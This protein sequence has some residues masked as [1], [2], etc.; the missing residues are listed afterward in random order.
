MQYKH[1]EKQQSTKQLEPLKLSHS[2][3]MVLAFSPFLYQE[4]LACASLKM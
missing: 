3:S 4:H 1:W 2:S